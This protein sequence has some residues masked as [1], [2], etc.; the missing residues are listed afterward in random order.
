MA[1]GLSTDLRQQFIYGC[2]RLS[3]S[4]ELE[5]ILVHHLNKISC[6]LQEF[7]ENGMIVYIRDLEGYV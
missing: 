5:R 3:I 1:N 6:K 4:Q 7:I 2:F